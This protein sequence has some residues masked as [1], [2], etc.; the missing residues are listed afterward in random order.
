MI[1]RI[2]KY[3]DAMDGGSLMAVGQVGVANTP[4]AKALDEALAT[5]WANKTQA[6]LARLARTST[7]TI[8]RVLT[9]K[10]TKPTNAASRIF[11]VLGLNA[12]AIAKGETANKTPIEHDIHSKLDEVLASPFGEAVRI[13]IQ[14]L[15]QSLGD[16]RKR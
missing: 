13:Q 3:L 12:D 2:A 15:Y 6:D 9:G 16:H 7:Q 4:L 14:S 10:I 1:N 5:T 11:D 8:Y